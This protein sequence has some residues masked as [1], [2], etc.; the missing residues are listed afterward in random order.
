MKGEVSGDDRQEKIGPVN[1]RVRA[2]QVTDQKS[3]LAERKSAGCR[4]GFRRFGAAVVV[5]FAVR[6]WSGTGKG[7]KKCRRCGLAEVGQR[8]DY[9]S[10][11]FWVIGSVG[12]L[13]LAKS[14]P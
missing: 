9:A 3:G 13:G 7:Q 10:N 1:L 8:Q 5:H 14:G 12:R 4:L 2:L 11:T 6:G